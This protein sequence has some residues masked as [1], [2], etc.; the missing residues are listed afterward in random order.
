M[1]L[2]VYVSQRDGLCSAVLSILRAIPRYILGILSSDTDFWN[3][4]WLLQYHDS[5]YGI[6]PVYSILLQALQYPVT[7]KIDDDHLIPFYNFR[8]QAILNWGN[9]IMLS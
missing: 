4:I 8:M 9:R 5:V 6:D 7:S 2:F 1:I 3:L